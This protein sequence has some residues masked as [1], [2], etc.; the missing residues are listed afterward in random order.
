MTRPVRQNGRSYKG[1]N[2]FL[3]DDMDALSAVVAGQNAIR[4]FRSRDLAF[5]LPDLSSS[6]RSRLI[7]RLRTHGIIKKVAYTY[8]YYLSSFGRRVIAAGLHLK[9]FVLTP[10]LCPAA[11]G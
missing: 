11:P 2:F 6:R 8:K 10:Q 4:G 7:E 3:A 1:F 5:A 9:T